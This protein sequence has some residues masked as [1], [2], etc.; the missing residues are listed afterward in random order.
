MKKIKPE[1]I[2]QL[3]Y[4]LIKNLSINTLAS[5]DMFVRT[6]NTKNGKLKKI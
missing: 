2:I 3:L 1:I 4:Q 5:I 6:R